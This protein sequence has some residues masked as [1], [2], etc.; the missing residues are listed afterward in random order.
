MNTES[1]RIQLSSFIYL[2]SLEY[3]GIHGCDGVHLVV[4]CQHFREP[5]A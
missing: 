3:Y 2:F 1:M 5:A 4:L